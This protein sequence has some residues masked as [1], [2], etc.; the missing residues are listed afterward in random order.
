MRS[1]ASAS[2]SL[3][4][5]T[6]RSPSAC[7]TAAGRLRTS[8]APSTRRA[9][10]CPTTLRQP[11]LDD[12]FLAK[13]GRPLE[14]TEGEEPEPAAEAE[15]AQPPAEPEEEPRKAAAGRSRIEKLPTAMLKDWMA[16]RHVQEA[17][18]AAKKGIPLLAI[19]RPASPARR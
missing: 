11:S 10:P 19:R 15:A 6:A 5:A 12:V 3:Q 16:E 14:A 17:R 7:V 18:E 1:A 9:S 8:C 13:T 4:R 2:R